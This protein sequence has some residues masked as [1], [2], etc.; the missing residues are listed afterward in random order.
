MQ[1]VLAALLAAPVAA[2]QPAVPADSLRNVLLEIREADQAPRLELM[3]LMATHDNAPPDSLLLPLALWMRQSD[4]EQLARLAPLIDR[5]GWPERSVVGEEAAQAAFLVVQHAP[6]DVQE[7][8]LPL[9]EAAV[10]EGEAAP[11]DLALLT[12]RVLTFRGEPQRYGSQVTSVNGARAFHP[13]EDV[14]T[15]DARRA[16]VGLEPLAAYAERLGAPLPEGYPAPED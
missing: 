16:E 1:P 6:A 12:D 9:L 14:A 8:Y 15:V 7:L 10:A 3:A 4:A 2:A 13:I 11:G 5:Y